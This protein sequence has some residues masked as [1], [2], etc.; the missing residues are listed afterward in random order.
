M[1]AIVFSVFHGAGKSTAMKYL[2]EKG[3]T[4]SDSDSSEFNFKMSECGRHYLDVNGDI[5]DNK[6]ER[7]KNPNFISDYMQAIKS[8]GETNDI[9]FVSSHDEIRKA[10]TDNS[11]SFT[12]V[13]YQN[14]IKNVVVERIRNRDTNQPNEAIANFLDSNWDMFIDG[15]VDHNPSK[16]FYLGSEQYVSDVLCELGFC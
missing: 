15:M 11:I 1:K 7:V 12:M 8:R 16:I 9:V 13:G 14:G 4:V 3:Y 10:L 2:T 6:D 5:T